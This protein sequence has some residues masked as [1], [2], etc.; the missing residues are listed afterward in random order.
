M[1]GKMFP[2]RWEEPIQEKAANSLGFDPGNPLVM[3]EITRILARGPNV[4]RNLQIGEV[5]PTD[6]IDLK[7]ESSE[8]VSKEAADDIL[9]ELNLLPEPSS[10]AADSSKSNDASQP[11][12]KTNQDETTV[13]DSLGEP[14]GNGNSIE[15]QDSYISQSL[16]TVFEVLTGL[17]ILGLVWF[18]LR[19]RRR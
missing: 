3:T 15:I 16:L 10:E 18:L 6:L 1:Q 13:T 17:M 14:V 7:Q 19:R 8:E 12:S 11:A 9:R 2:H 5:A 4:R